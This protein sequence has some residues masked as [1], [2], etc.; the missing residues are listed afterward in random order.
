MGF[1][2]YGFGEFEDV[3]ALVAR[4]RSLGLL[5]LWFFFGFWRPWGFQGFK[6]CRGLE[7]QGFRASLRVVR[8]L[9]LGYFIRER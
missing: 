6:G 2:V 9:G 4:F 3:R 7:H 8:V 5:G 1:R